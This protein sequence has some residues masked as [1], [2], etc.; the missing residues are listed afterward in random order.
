MFGNFKCADYLFGNLLLYCQKA[1]TG[2]YCVKKIDV[3]NS[4][5]ELKEIFSTQY[6]GWSY[7][8]EMLIV[9]NV[10]TIVLF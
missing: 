4:S 5:L 1:K 8:A 9:V 7:I 6:Q 3:T 2:K 10:Y